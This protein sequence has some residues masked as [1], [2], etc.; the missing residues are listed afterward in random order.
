M[1]V[2]KLSSKLLVRIALR[3]GKVE[4]NRLTKRSHIVSLEK[5]SMMGEKLGR[6]ILFSRSEIQQNI[7]QLENPD[8]YENYF[9]ALPKIICDFF[10]ALIMVL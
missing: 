9:D 3:M 4:L 10:Q 2:A 8:S 1:K 5:T 6:E 7:S